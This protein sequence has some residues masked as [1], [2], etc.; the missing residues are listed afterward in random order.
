MKL[1]ACALLVLGAL[2]VGCAPAMPEA[3]NV[4]GNATLTSAEVRRPL[5]TRDP[6]APPIDT[7]DPWANEAPAPP[8]VQTWGAAQPAR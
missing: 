8:P 4:P 3:A 2:A 5:D 7:S 1:H 6:W